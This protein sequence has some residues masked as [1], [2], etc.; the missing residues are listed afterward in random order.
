MTDLSKIREDILQAALPHVQFD[1]W[2]EDV[3]KIAIEDTGLESHLVKSAFPRGAVDLALFYHGKGDCMMMDAVANADM[4]D[5]RYSEKVALAVRLR[6]EAVDKEA[7]RSGV[8]LFAMPQNAGDGAKALWGTVDAIWNAL[9]DT[10]EDVNWYTKRATLGA[11]YSTTVLYWIG[12]D[13]E[14]DQATWEFLDRRIENVMQFEKVKAKVKDTPVGKMFD[15]ATSWIKAPDPD[16]KS[17]FPGY[18]G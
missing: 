14:D 12:D 7:V 3:L 13:S 5:R 9:G 11:V 1:G 8:T 16:H 2:T 10:S 6:L 4:S 15:A 17:N 18:S